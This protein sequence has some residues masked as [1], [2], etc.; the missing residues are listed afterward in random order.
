M[1]ALRADVWA[2]LIAWAVTTAPVFFLHHKL[3]RRHMTRITAAQTEHMTAHIAAV[4]SNQ[5]AI[6]QNGT[7]P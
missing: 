2:D 7:P 5:T 3:L 6:L 1:S 4:T